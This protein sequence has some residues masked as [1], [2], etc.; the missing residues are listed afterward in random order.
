MKP[1]TLEWISK[2]EGDFAMMERE[3]R[4]RKQRNHDGICFLNGRRLAC[5][6]PCDHLRRNPLKNAL[7]CE[8][9]KL[10]KYEGT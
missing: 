1:I 2:A 8:P 4:A 6:S 3:G 5:Q 7:E 9:L 10:P